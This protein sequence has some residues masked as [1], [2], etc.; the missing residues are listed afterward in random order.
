MSSRRNDDK[1]VVQFILGVQ[2]VDRAL[3]AGANVLGLK[4]GVVVLNDLREAESFTYKFQDTLYRD[5]RASDRGS[6]E[7]N[8]RVYADPVSHFVPHFRVAL[9]DRVAVGAALAG[10]VRMFPSAAVPVG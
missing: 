4:G 2:Y 6:A 1:G 7:M 10:S 5:S 9:N 8:L 3:N